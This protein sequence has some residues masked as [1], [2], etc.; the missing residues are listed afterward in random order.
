[1]THTMIRRLGATL[2]AAAALAT[3]APTALAQ[4]PGEGPGGPILVL[5]DPGNPF[6]RYYAEILRAEGL[7]E[8]AVEDVG[9]LSPGMLNAYQVVILAEG[10]LDASNAALLTTWVNGGG[11][12]IAMRP[13]DELGGLL[14]LGADAGDVDSQYVTVASRAAGAGITA[15]SMQFHGTAPHAPPHS[16]RRH[17]TD[18]VPDGRRAR[19][20][21]AQRRRQRRAG[22]GVHLRPRPVGRADPPGRS[23]PGGKEARTPATSTRSFAATTCSSPTGSTCPRCG[24]PRP[25]SSSGCW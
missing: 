2:L 19:G 18:R 16:R 21:V 23:G 6:G 20:Y 25:T 15:Q 17:P 13:G 7:N 9:D 22:G 14:G 5:A 11:N 4:G 3:H 10:S 24:S 12:L 1:M 8:F